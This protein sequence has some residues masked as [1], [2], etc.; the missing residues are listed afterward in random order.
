MPVSEITKLVQIPPGQKDKLKS[1][2]TE[3]RPHFPPFVCLCWQQKTRTTGTVLT[4]IKHRCSNPC[5]GIAAYLVEIQCAELDKEQ[6]KTWKQCLPVIWSE[7]QSGDFSM[8]S[9]SGFSLEKQPNVDDVWKYNLESVIMIYYE[10]ILLV[11][12]KLSIYFT[13]DMHYGT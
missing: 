1:N 3:L 4:I 9:R 12:V 13:L 7:Q 6:K 8:L 10:I 11:V 5:K 2:E